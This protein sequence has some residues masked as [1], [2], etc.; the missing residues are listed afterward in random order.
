MSRLYSWLSSQPE[1]KWLTPGMRS[2]VIYP[3]QILTHIAGVNVTKDINT[4]GN[5]IGLIFLH[6]FR[7]V[8]TNTYNASNVEISLSLLGKQYIKRGVECGLYYFYTKVNKIYNTRQ[9]DRYILIMIMIWC[10]SDTQEEKKIL[11]VKL[12][13]A[14]VMK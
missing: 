13:D 8:P 10:R 6:R 7:I 4:Q 3:S 5:K 9:I 12:Q 14:K 11:G 2:A 1:Y